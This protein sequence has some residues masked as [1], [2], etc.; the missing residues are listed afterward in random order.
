MK[1]IQLLKR[2]LSYYWRTN[3]VVVLGVATAVAVLS[4]ALLVGDSVRAS[5]RDLVVQRLGQTDYVITSTGFFREQ[6]ASD[7]Q[8][9]SQFATAEFAAACP[10][11]ALPGTVTHEP[12]RRIASSIKVYGV[13]ERFWKF[14]QLQRVQSNSN[15]EISL[16]EGL[17]RE[18]GAA[19]GDS[20]VLRVEKPSAIPLESLHSRKEDLGSTVRLTVRE[21]LAA[22]ALGEFSLQ[23]QQ[24]VVRAVFVPLTLLQKE[25]DQTGKAN[26]IL[27]ADNS[28]S[29][30]Q[31][32]NRSASLER[33]IKDRTSL[34]DYGLKLRVVD[35]Q[36]ALSVE[37]FAG[38]VSDSLTERVETA[39]KP[40]NTSG[41]W[42]FLSYLVNGIRKDNGSEIP[43]SIVTGVDGKMLESMQHDEVGH[44]SGCD[45]SAF[46]GSVPATANLPPILLNEW[47]RNDLQAQIGER[48]TLSYYV[49]LPQG[50]LD[51]RSA[52][53]RVACIL[54]MEGLAVDRDLVP[55]Y[56]G[57][58][59]SETFADWD[60]PFPIDLKRVRPQDEAYWK[61]YRTSPK[62]FVP[63]EVAQNLWGSRFG[64]LTSLRIWPNRGGTL[65]ETS[66][67]FE[68]SLRA[69]LEPLQAGFSILP[70][71]AQGLEASR[72]ATDFGEYFL[73]FSFFLV[74]SALM[75]TALF[76]KLGIEQ[77]LREIGVLGAIGFPAARI[78]R[79][80][81]SEGLMLAVIGSLLGLAGAIGYGEFVLVGLRTW[82]VDAVGT[83]MLRLHISPISLAIGAAGG[84]L[85]ALLCVVWTLRGLG[86][87]STRS[88]L[89][90]I[91]ADSGTTARP[92]E[93]HGVRWFSSFAIGSTLG[94]LGIMLLIAA[95]LNF[96]NQVAGFFGSGT[97]LLAAFL[98]YQAASLRGRSGKPIVSLG[99]WSVARLGFRNATSR[100][101]RSVLCIALIASAAFIIVA[102]DS[103]R[104]RDA[105]Q[106]L[107]RKSGN[108]GFP[109]LA[110]SVLPL[111]HDPNTSEGQQALNLSDEAGLRLAGANFTR[112]RLRPGDDASCLNLYQPRN[113][114]IIAPTPDF[115]GSNRFAFQSS[116]AT[117]AEEK[118][119]PWLLLNHEFADGAVP[120]I[121]DANSMTY[122]LHLKLGDDLNVDASA[123]P[124]RFRVVASL[125]DSVFQSELLMAESNFVRLFP[126]QQGYRFFLIDTPATEQT[127]AIASTLEDRLSDFGFDVQST[128]DRL[129]S[130]HRVENTYLSTFQM[131]G[132][133]GLVLGTL[134]MAAVLLRN[135]LERRRELALLRAVG[136]N[137]SHF[138]MMVLA[139]NSLL[140]FS[141]LITG[142]VSALLAIA[143]VLFSRQAQLPSLSLGLLLLGVLISGLAASLF[144]TWAALR[145][146][147]LAALRA[148]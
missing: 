71:R 16:S 77:R 4:G 22:D 84:V 42:P 80:F 83:T 87:K 122:V 139:E 68:Q 11:I 35:K 51:T 20:I 6:L 111:V 57:I 142:A 61:T 126:D 41:A 5:L 108:G 79:L 49:W 135:V 40:A 106:T 3:V 43:Y 64:K 115:V 21:V 76:F 88:L 65:E 127:S 7:I 73:Y 34:E 28:N 66:P 10:L 98:C 92:G 96:V 101:G 12:S 70:V 23:P 36:Q 148:E 140:L 128:A 8:S 54:P 78:R 129:A 24:G 132:G 2:S 38:F 62:A 18:L 133:L 145:S 9:D 107:D 14:H 124:V 93:T 137:S 31:T 94:L 56:P 19:A 53:F 118:N 131:L 26:L 67:A 45:A 146:P 63:L 90:G 105:A 75:L 47:A 110:E 33:I 91:T 13:D 82:W 17:A 72:G 39:A 44:R 99:W 59:E 113:P 119:N 121:V 125:A 1:P 89:S 25:L 138:A 120:I 123:G 74:V 112:F 52:E 117:T 104:H 141:G 134:G 50:R 95:W 46:R 97:L 147:L 100:P 29:K 30:T 60:P 86:K 143:P 81:L 136:Y 114:R 48:V 103:F 15:R 27:V 37:S 85:A 109:L 55:D 69:T 130:F 144:A 116:L 102:V 58:T 32:A